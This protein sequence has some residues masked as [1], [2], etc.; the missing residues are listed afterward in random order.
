MPADDDQYLFRTTSRPF[1]ER[2][3]R[4]RHWIAGKQHYVVTTVLEMHPTRDRLEARWTVRGRSERDDEAC[5]VGRSATSL[6]RS[7]DPPRGSP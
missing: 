3:M 7:A 2:L 6:A 1:A 5:P 4:D